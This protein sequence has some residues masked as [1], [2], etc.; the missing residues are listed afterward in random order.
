MGLFRR[1]GHILLRGAAALEE[2]AKFRPLILAAWDHHGSEATP[3]ERR[4]TYGKAFLFAGKVVESRRH[5]VRSVG[6]LCRRT[7]PSV[8]ALHFG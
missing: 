5:W 6:G 7:M 1:D 4:D 2:V 8:A 3:L